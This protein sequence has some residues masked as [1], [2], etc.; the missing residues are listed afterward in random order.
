MD[1]LIHFFLENKPPIEITISRQLH[2]GNENAINLVYD[3]YGAAIFG[4]CLKMLG[5]KEAAEEVF[6][7]SMIKIWK[8]GKKFDPEKARLYTWMIS[9]TR[10]NCID[11]LRKIQRA[12]QIQSFESNVSIAEGI[13]GDEVSVDHI[14][15]K[16]ELDK[17][18][19][20]ER[21]IIDLSYFQGFTQNEI[22]TKLNLPLG[23]VKT[24]A[25]RA[26]REL[27][28]LLAKDIES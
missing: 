7:E 3:H 21:V 27:K 10:N 25:R 18:D 22:S 16:K 2:D 23:T 9:I 19:E 14:G 12:P 28:R 4:F 17:L 5:D 6:Q 11:Y 1:F 8:Y 15:L 26:L 24:R 13:S 20:E